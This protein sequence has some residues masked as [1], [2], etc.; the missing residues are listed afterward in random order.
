[1]VVNM[2]YESSFIFMLFIIYSIIGWLMETSF[3]TIITKKFTNR[4][5]FMGPYC[6]IYGIG[7]LL[8]LY[9]LK[10]YQSEPLAL[11][12][13]SIVICSLLEYTTSFLMEK[14]FKNRWWDYSNRKFNINGRICLETMIPFGLIG[15]FIFYGLNPFITSIISTI[16]NIVL[17]IISFFLLLIFLIDIIISLNIIVKFKNISNNIKTDSTD[18]ITKKVKEIISNKSIFQKRLTNAFPN[19]KIK[20]RK[21]K[22]KNY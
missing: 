5:F 6:P 13:M 9:L 21:D 15:T 3:N 16:P 17:I 1:M 18:E 14:I 12:V 22:T 11:F 10:R 7:V 20:I 19:M 8:I 4:G 2:F